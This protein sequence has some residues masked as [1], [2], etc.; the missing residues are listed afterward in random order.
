MKSF[1]GLLSLSGL[2]LVALTA[3][4]ACHNADT[5]KAGSPAEAAKTYMTYAYEKNYGQFANAFVFSSDTV[6]ASRHEANVR[7]VQELLEE[8]GE[9]FYVSMDSVSQINILSEQIDETGTRANVTL[10]TVC[11]SGMRDTTVHGLV[12]GGDGWKFYEDK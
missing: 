8:K 2:T 7:A 5:P 9:D 3:L 10:E 6:E 1:S 11:R 4:T 12:K